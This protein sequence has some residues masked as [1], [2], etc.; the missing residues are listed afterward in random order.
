MPS[1]ADPT[2]PPR[3]VDA[4][5]WR[6]RCALRDAVA[7]LPYA[8]A[9]ARLLD[10]LERWVKLAL[11][12]G[13]TAPGAPALVSTGPAWAAVLYAVAASAALVSEDSRALLAPWLALVPAPPRAP[14]AGAAGAAA[15]FHPLAGPGSR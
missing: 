4:T 2:R 8:T 9:E 6:L 13:Q 14:G 11:T 12:P 1:G 15:D 10:G 5:A 7:R 3:G